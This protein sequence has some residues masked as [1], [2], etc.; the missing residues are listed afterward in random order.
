[1]THFHA[2][3]LDETRCEFGV[4]FEAP[5]REAAYDYLSENYPESRC[6]QLEDP[7]QS[8]ERER[9]TYLRAMEDDGYDDYEE[10]Y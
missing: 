8:A 4:S 10:D 2:V 3:M 9:Q 6:V 5:D 7:S 1:M